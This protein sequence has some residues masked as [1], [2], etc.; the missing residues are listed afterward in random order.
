MICVRPAF[1]AKRLIGVAVLF[2]A[3]GWLPAFAQTPASNVQ[4]V[5]EPGGEKVQRVRWA[6]GS[7]DNIVTLR[8]PLGYTS[9]WAAAIGAWVGPDYGD[10]T[11]RDRKSATAFSFAALLPDM[12]VRTKEN[13]DEFTRP[14]GGDKVEGVVDSAIREGNWRRERD[15]LNTDLK[16]W[17]DRL[18]EV[19]PKRPHSMAVGEKPE[20]FGLKRI[21]PTSIAP[22]QGSRVR[23]RDLY[24]QGEAPESSPFFIVCEAEEVQTRDE[25]P[26]Q[27]MVGQCQQF[28]IFKPLSA[29]A[30]FGY[31]R[32]FLKDWRQIQAGVE[33]LLTSF[34]PTGD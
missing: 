9:L 33:R 2:A 4:V 31:R 24:Y 30:E 13:F 34:L 16:I 26:T 1:S 32:V 28:M 5:T 12:A 15:R 3:A 11:L 7:P 27:R 22:V 20:R 19:T 17:R 6:I 8:I 14:G 21:G 10:Q 25:D 29:V 18:I 23:L